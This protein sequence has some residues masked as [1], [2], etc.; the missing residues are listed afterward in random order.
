[1]VTRLSPSKVMVSPHLHPQERGHL[2]GDHGPIIGQ[3][4]GDVIGAVAQL[5]ETAQ[6]LLAGGGLEVAVKV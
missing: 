4:D 5:H 1:M 6:F 2:F 3:C